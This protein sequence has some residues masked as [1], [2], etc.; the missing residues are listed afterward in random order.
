MHTITQEQR[1]HL[2]TEEIAR[3]SARVKDPLETTVVYRD[4]HTT[5]L[6]YARRKRSVSEWFADGLTGGIV[7]IIGLIIHILL[8]VISLGLWILVM[9]IF[10]AKSSNDVQAGLEIITVQDTGAIKSRRDLLMNEKKV[11]KKLRKRA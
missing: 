9:V 7:G 4:D 8:I 6:K 10:M 1:D 2:L 5:C 3:R 11:L